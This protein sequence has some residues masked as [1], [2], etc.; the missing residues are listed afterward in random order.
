MSDDQDPIIHI[1][2]GWKAQVEKEREQETTEP[3]SEEE[4][5]PEQQLSPFE[6][7][8]SG[9]AAQ[10]VMALGLMSEQ[11]GQ[12]VMV[13]LDMA[14]SL[15]DTLIML[16]DMTEGNR[17]ESESANLDEAVTELERV[18]GVRMEQVREMQM[19]KPNSDPNPPFINQ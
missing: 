4:L 18:F 7:H 2:E 9:L 10:T 11:E 16:K 3:E 1:D 17:S 5:P 15:I 12:E 19:N 14:R 13:D 8:V 6:Y